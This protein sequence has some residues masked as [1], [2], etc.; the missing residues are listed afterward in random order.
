[1]IIS[2]VCQVMTIFLVVKEMMIYM[3]AWGM[4]IS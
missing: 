1:M 4:T 2:W 3:V